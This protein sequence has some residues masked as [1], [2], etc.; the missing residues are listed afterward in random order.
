[1]DR[2]MQR[3]TLFLVSLAAFLIPFMG[4]SLSLALPVIQKE[5]VVN[6]IILG[7]IP[8]AFVLANA[9]TVL[10][11]GRLSDIYGRKRIFSYG[12]LIYTTA[13]LLAAF[14]NSGEILVF[15]SFLQGLGCA[16][17]FATMVA[18]L[19]S[20]FPMERRGEALGLYVSAVFIGLFLGPILGGVLIQYLGWRSIYLFNIPVGI[21]LLSILFW[22]LRMEWAEAQGES[23][24]IKGALIYS[25]SLVAL[26]YGFSSLLEDLG[27][28]V[29]VAGFLGILG[30]FLMERR[31]ESP[32]L[33]FDIFKSRRS[34]FT[35]LSMLFLNI[36][37]SAM[38]TF[39]SLYFQSLR[40]LEPQ[41]T[42]FIL[43][44]QPLMVAVLSPVIG[45]AAD[46]TENRFLPIGGL[47]LIT[48]GLLML[49]FLS[50]ET[51]ILVPVLALILVGVGQAMFSSPTTRI[52]M[53]SVDSKIYGMA[54]SA[55]STMIY[56]GQT[57]SLALMLFIFAIYL[58]QVEINPSNYQ[59][60]LDSMRVAF[61]VFSIISGLALV[62]SILVGPNVSK[63][64]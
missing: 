58:G 17:I 25:L 51:I 24:D 29:L 37:I 3:I 7:W 32:I 49:S 28:T 54:S 20:V 64:K 10:P 14:S 34:S 16:M 5:L 42:A 55:F 26:L 22:K 39:L 19:S 15:F 1:M 21:I 50:Q 18:L 41:T 56:L 62:F 31:T 61:L 44:A 12:V 2:S 9:A 38:A 33:K 8:T 63:N 60:F 35:A 40:G 13:S 46:R 6:V 43:A 48:A 53:G 47:I 57:L 4:S 11:F 30:F 36:A 27:K 52:F 23:F 59:V 45:R